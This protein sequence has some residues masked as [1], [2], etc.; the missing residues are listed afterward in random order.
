MQF[1]SDDD[2]LETLLDDPTIKMV[3]VST[4]ALLDDDTA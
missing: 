1:V 3:F 4:A 2:S